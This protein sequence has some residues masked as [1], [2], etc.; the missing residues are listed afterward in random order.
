MH[1]LEAKGIY[2]STGSACSSHKKG[3]SSVLLSQGVKQD[4]VQGTIRI[5][6]GLFNT[7]EEMTQA[8]EVICQKAAYLARFKRR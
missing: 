7:M 3:L 6:L 1:S 8:G 2:V 5:S 4:A